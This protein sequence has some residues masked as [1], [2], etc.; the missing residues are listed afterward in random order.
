[1]DKLVTGFAG[2]GART[3]ALRML[4]KEARKKKQEQEQKPN[5]H[6][7]C[8]TTEGSLGT[9]AIKEITE[10][11]ISWLFHEKQIQLGSL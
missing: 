3:K 10:D 5:V 2:Y 11:S 8:N 7:S 1:M 6:S 4:E 9:P